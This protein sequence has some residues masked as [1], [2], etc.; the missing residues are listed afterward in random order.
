MATS[1]WNKVIP[2]VV[3]ELLACSATHSERCNNYVEYDKCVE[4]WY[5]RGPAPLVGSL[6]GTEATGNAAP[7]VSA[8]L[9]QGGKLRGP[10]RASSLRIT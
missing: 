7:R 2:I 1:L 5:E 6:A 4:A 3:H 9:T 8:A 10:A